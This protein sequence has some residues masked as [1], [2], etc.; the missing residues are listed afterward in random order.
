MEITSYHQYVRFTNSTANSLI[1]IAIDLQ[2]CAAG[3]GITLAYGEYWD[4]WLGESRVL[5]DGAKI[6]AIADDAG[7]VLSI[8]VL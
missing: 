4:Y 6:Y 5:F 8:A 7:R 2:T 3:E 1:T